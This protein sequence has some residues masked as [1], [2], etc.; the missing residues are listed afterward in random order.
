MSLWQ[1]REVDCSVISTSGL[2]A[3]CASHFSFNMTLPGFQTYSMLHTTIAYSLYRINYPISPSYKS[4]SGDPF[5]ALFCQRNPSFI[6]IYIPEIG[7]VLRIC[8]GKLQMCRPL[9]SFT[10]SRVLNMLIRCFWRIPYE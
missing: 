10:L 3:T 7:V 9:T 8:A 1:R 5:R 2:I 6:V 4:P